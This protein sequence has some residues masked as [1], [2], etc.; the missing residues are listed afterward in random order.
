MVALD[1]SCLDAAYL[2]GRLFALLEAIQYRA[3]GQTNSTVVTRY[4]STASTRPVAAFAP[5]LRGAQAHL[6]KLRRT[7]DK[8]GAYVRLNARLQ[9]LLEL[10]PEQAFPVAL[11]VLQQCR[12]H[13]GYYHQRAA[14]R[15]ALL[16]AL[17]R[18]GLKGKEEQLSEEALANISDETE[19]EASVNEQRA[20]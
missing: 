18:K 10:F 8:R 1:E 13:L 11:P 7:P 14:D 19:G 5:L 20:S 2:S 12:F 16:E 15:A 4:Y 9:S 17:A 3:L 6:S